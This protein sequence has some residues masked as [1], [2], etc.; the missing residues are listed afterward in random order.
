MSA[1]QLYVDCGKVRSRKILQGKE[2][3]NV[4]EDVELALDSSEP[5]LLWEQEIEPNIKA[6][7]QVNQLDLIPQKPTS[8][9]R[10]R[11][12]GAGVRAGGEDETWLHI[13]HERQI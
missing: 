13:Y 2:I 3:I 4:Q 1:L 7:P 6:K 8:T 9:A 10:R 5:G 11:Q 12:E